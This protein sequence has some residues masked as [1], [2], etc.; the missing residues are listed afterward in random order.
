MDNLRNLPHAPSVQMN[1]VPPDILTF[2]DYGED[3]ERSADQSGYN[4][5]KSGIVKREH[6]AEYY[7]GPN[8]IDR[9]DPDAMR[10]HVR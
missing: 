6:H 5:E 2:D 10:P 1:E 8:D 7:N 9:D 3:E 4:T